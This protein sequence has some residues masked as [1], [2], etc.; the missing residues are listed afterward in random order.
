MRKTNM[1]QKAIDADRMHGPRRKQGRR[2]EVWHRT[3]DDSHPMFNRYGKWMK[4]RHYGDESHARA[5]V[6]KLMRQSNASRWMYRVVDT[7][8]DCVVYEVIP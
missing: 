1:L 4:L 7:E 3:K 5:C 2:F 8:L 6:E